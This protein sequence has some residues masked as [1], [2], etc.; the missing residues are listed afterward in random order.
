MY[1]RGWSGKG[2]YPLTSG[3]AYREVDQVKLSQSLE[4]FRK[5]LK[6][7]WSKF[8]RLALINGG[9]PNTWSPSGDR[10]KTLRS[11]VRAVITGKHHESCIRA[12]S[13]LFASTAWFYL[14]TFYS[15][16]P[17]EI[18]RLGTIF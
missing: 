16:V 10:Y 14:N 18:L 13:T 4:E 1:M 7:E 5:K 15:E 8:A 6:G 12:T 17:F 3:E 9:E 2:D 11:R